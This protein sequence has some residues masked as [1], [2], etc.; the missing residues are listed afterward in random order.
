MKWTPW[1]V[2][3]SSNVWLVSLVD[4]A[5]LEVAILGHF[6]SIWTIGWNQVL[7]PG[8]CGQFYSLLHPCHGVICDRWVW[9]FH[10]FRNGRSGLFQGSFFLPFLKIGTMSALLQSSGTSP[11]FHNFRQ[12]IDSGSER[13]SA[14]SF[15][16]LGCSSWSPGNL[17]SFKKIR[18]SLTICLSIW[19]CNPDLQLR[20]I[21]S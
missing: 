1:V 14:S 12:I 10:S 7:E 6:S 2:V 18:S 21:E 11:V 5:Q 20:I 19:Y 4:L 3:P 15:I 13:S 8:F 17:N 9:S 16:I